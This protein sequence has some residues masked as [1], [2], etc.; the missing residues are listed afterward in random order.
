AA[1][2][3]PISSAKLD[4][5]LGLRVTGVPQLERPATVKL[6]GPYVSGRGVRIPSFDW[7]LTASLAGF[8]VDGEL[9]ST[10]QNLYVSVYGDNYEVGRDVIA[11]ANRRIAAGSG[12]DLRRWL[13]PAR[14]EGEDEVGGVDTAHLVADLRGG[15]V[16]HDLS[17]Q[18][19]GLGL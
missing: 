17:A 15:R 13:G 11:H 9:V 16:G 6:E 5:D 3:K 18:F 8:P 7:D 14:D 2:A 12:I 4:A 10:G 19:E 1:F